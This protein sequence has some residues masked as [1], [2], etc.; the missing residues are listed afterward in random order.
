MMEVRQFDYLKYGNVDLW[1]LVEL[2]NY[3]FSLERTGSPLLVSAIQ[4]TKFW[5]FYTLDLGSNSNV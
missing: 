2:P 3:V 5:G 1:V 4:D